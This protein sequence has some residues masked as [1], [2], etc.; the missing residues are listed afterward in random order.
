MEKTQNP[1]QMTRENTQ[2]A[3]LEATRHLSP[4][5]GRAGSGGMSSVSPV[6]LTAS[7]CLRLV[8]GRELIPAPA[9]GMVKSRP[10]CRLLAFGQK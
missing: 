9:F 5:G 3:V 8:L 1:T 10:E 2:E 6:T 7:T 4:A